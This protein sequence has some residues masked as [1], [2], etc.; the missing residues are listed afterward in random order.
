MEFFKEYLM[1]SKLIK[2]SKILIWE[3]RILH[4]KL[5]FNPKLPNLKF[6]VSLTLSHLCDISD[7]GVKGFFWRENTINIEFIPRDFNMK[8]PFYS[9]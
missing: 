5:I 4:K 9:Y 7:L 2:K 6:Y 3:V 1:C 8:K